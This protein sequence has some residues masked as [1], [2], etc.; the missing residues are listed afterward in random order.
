MAV[1]CSWSSSAVSISLF[2]FSPTAKS[3]EVWTMR[4]FWKPLVP[5]LL[6]LDFLHL[7]PC[8]PHLSTLYHCVSIVLWSCELCLSGRI[9]IFSL[10]SSKD[11]WLH[12][13]K[14]SFLAS[15]LQGCPWGL[16]CPKLCHIEEYLSYFRFWKLTRV[17][18]NWRLT[19]ISTIY[20]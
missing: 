10:H 12:C 6:L 13:Q 2:F 3:Q 14:M 20:H 7:T 9:H 18:L 8:R 4:T 19:I 16:Q 17:F 5:V 15:S 1:C 11:L